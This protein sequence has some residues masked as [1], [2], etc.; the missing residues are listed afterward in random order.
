M[1]KTTNT[2]NW[3]EI[4]V[5]SFERAKKFYET[6]F[7]CEMHEQQ[8]GP[9]RMGF[10]PSEPGNGKLSGSI[11]HGEGYKPG[12]DGPIVYFNGNPNLQTAL[13]K[14]ENAGGKVILPKTEITPEIGY[15]AMFLDTEG[16]R[17]A[18]HSQK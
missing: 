5:V 1:D 8:M 13:D 18:L 10:F 4:P 16:N 6:I 9:Y 2:L 3:F 14:V 7:D 11:I 12:A 17:V 15:F